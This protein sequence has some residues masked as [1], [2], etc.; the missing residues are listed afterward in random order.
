MSGENDDGVEC[1]KKVGIRALICIRPLF[2]AGS[3]G[4]GP[5]RHILKGTLRSNPSIQVQPAS[6]QTRNC[7]ACLGLILPTRKGRPPLPHDRKS[8]KRSWTNLPAHFCYTFTP[9]VTLAG[10]SWQ[11][12]SNFNKSRFCSEL[13]LPSFRIHRRFVSRLKFGWL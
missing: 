12:H 3:R 5:K 6:V 1:R 4:I 9:P 10:S 11:Y 8:W 2:L 13:T 7:L